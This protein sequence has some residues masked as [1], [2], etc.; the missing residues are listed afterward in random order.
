MILHEASFM[1]FSSF[2]K[3]KGLKDDLEICP[4]FFFFFL[5]AGFLGAPYNLTARAGGN[6]DSKFAFR[7]GINLQPKDPLSGKSDPYLRVRLG[8]NSISDR[9]N[10]IA[11][12][13]NPTFGR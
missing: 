10:Y 6:R 12:Q 1:Y 11:N 9:K 13:L 8:K 5:V 7:A 3:K 2:I 4:V